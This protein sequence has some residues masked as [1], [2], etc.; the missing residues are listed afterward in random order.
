MAAIRYPAAHAQMLY[1]LRELRDLRLQRFEWKSRSDDVHHLMEMLEN[2]GILDVDA[3]TLI[4]GSLRSEAEAEAVHAL[5]DALDLLI[6]EVEREQLPDKRAAAER[7]SDTRAI[8]GMSIWP[9]VVNSAREAY[10]ILVSS[11]EAR[12]EIAWALDWLISLE[13]ASDAEAS[14]E[15]SHD[16]YCV[17]WMNECLDGYAEE[18]VGK[19]LKN[20][21]EAGAIDRFAT[22]FNSILVSVEWNASE[23]VKHPRFFRLI[24]LAR[25][26]HRMIR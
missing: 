22:E 1:C 7:W 19:S 15:M 17:L 24:E 11:P 21:E 9:N 4:G 16:V 6:K 2:S 12:P 18:L 23:Y 8:M 20:L 25:D 5:S 26:A 3:K 10:R 13:Q 14:D